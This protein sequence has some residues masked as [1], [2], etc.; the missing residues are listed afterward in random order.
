MKSFNF[1]AWVG[2]VWKKINVSGLVI[3]YAIILI[4]NYLPRIIGEE[5]LL[6][7][8]LNFISNLWNDVKPILIQY[9][10][11][12]PYLFELALFL[13][14]SFLI[15]LWAFIKS[16]PP[17]GVK[18]H[19][20]TTDLGQIIKIAIENNTGHE[21]T[22]CYLEIRKIIGNLEQEYWY[23]LPLK[24]CYFEDNKLVTNKFAT[25]PD[26]KS[27]QF[28][29]ASPSKE[30]GVGYLMTCASHDTFR[31]KDQIRIE[32]LFFGKSS[33]GESKKKIFEVSLQSSGKKTWIKKVWE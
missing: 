7:L 11:E 9:W 10:L 22:E 32:L 27:I 3:F 2:R 33:N 18:V 29:I 12:K 28:W 21:L 19:P 5:V 24:C 4:I 1:F 15:L 30:D 14:C 20:G 25:I 23:D 26:N 13:F 6:R 8:A 31:F 16:Q 17:N